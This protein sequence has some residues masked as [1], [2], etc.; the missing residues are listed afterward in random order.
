MPLEIRV[1]LPHDR[2]NTGTL[3]LVDNVTGLRVFG[4]VPALGRGARNTAAAHGNPNGVATQP[5]GDTPLGGYRVPRVLSSG[6]GTNHPA[7]VYGSAGV[8]VLDPTSG[9]AQAAEN[10]GRT[11]LLIH[12]GRQVATPTPLPSHLRPTNGCIRVLEP[13]L[14]A[15]IQALRDYA[16][17]FPGDVTVSVG[18]N[19][20][21]GTI[22]EAV[23][24]GDPPD[25]TGSVVLP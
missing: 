12:A 18:P 23:D 5:F 15:L 9:D 2:R 22:D 1:L 8:I 25:T 19:G 16:F 7:N 4:P 20:P 3:E 17:L 24:D 11:G 6:A 13:D 14:A 10:N 21:Q